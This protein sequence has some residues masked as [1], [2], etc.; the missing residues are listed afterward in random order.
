MNLD[1]IMPIEKWVQVEQEINRRSGLNAAVYNEGT[2][3]EVK[4][5]ISIRYRNPR[6]PIIDGEQT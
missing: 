3:T 6:S 5:M 1:D 4:K 2:M